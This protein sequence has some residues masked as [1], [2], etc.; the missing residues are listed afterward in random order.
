MKLHNPYCHTQDFK[1][2]WRWKKE[3]K[4]IFDKEIEMRHTCWCST[5]IIFV[6]YRLKIEI[7]AVCRL[8]RKIPYPFLEL[9]HYQM[10]TIKGQLISKGLFGIL[11]CSKKW[12]KKIDYYDTSGQIVFLLFLEQL[13]MPKRHFDWPKCSTLL[14]DF[15]SQNSLHQKTFKMV[16]LS[17]KDE[18]TIWVDDI[19]SKN[20][21]VEISYNLPNGELQK[22]D[23]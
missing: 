2:W 12:T 14:I 3:R 6:N 22:L 1:L 20:C 19:W 16:S 18:K 8:W 11:N 7:K 10:V 23:Q 5:L 9:W 4:N 15:W 13:K 17:N 21:W